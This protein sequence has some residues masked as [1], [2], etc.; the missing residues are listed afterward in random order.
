MTQ[1]TWAARTT[2][3]VIDEVKRQRELRKWSAQRLS[4]ECAALGF[5]IS[6]NTISDLENHRRAHFGIPELIVFARALDIPPLLLLYPVGHQAEAEVWPGEVRPAFRAALWF[7]GEAPVP[8]EAVPGGEVIVEAEWDSP[9]RPLVMY[10]ENDAL[11]R[12]EFG[13]LDTAQKLA[14]AAASVPGTNQENA[15]AAVALWRD[16]AESHREN[17][18]RIRRAAAAE[19]LIPPARIM[20]LI[21][22]ETKDG[23]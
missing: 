20:G 9:A 14:E 1:E 8:V 15:A 13:S 7:T 2:W 6:R 21:T 17:G 11:F 5:S 12:K 23:E 4:E 19:G 3:A 18:E 16:A 22:D 10:R